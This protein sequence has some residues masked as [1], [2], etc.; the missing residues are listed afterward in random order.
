ML[1]ASFSHHVQSI[2]SG[3][4]RP[5]RCRITIYN[6]PQNPSIFHRVAHVRCRNPS[7]SQG[8]SQGHYPTRRL[9]FVPNGG[10]STRRNCVLSRQAACT[11]LMNGT[12]L[13]VF[14]LST[15]APQAASGRLALPICRIIVHLPTQ[16][17]RDIRP[18]VPLQDLR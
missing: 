4:G 12:D 14:Y 13:N 10:A 16:G 9:R 5:A 15:H 2:T 6:V 17:A 3:L 18:E 11:Q 7:M 8:H 1:L